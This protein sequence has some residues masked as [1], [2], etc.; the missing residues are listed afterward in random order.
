MPPEVS[1]LRKI[2]AEVS[3]QFH[4]DSCFSDAAGSVFT[5]AIFGMKSNPAA[6]GR[7]ACKNHKFLKALS[8]PKH[9]WSKDATNCY[10]WPVS[11]QDT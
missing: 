5:P 7:Q 3:L 11:S 8:N 2:R 1:S 4:P 9:L 6:E 10:P